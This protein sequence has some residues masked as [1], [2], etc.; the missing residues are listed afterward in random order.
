MKRKQVDFNSKKWIHDILEEQSSEE[1][2]FP[3]NDSEILNKEKKWFNDTRL[4][5]LFANKIDEKAAWLQTQN[6][7]RAPR[8][9]TLK[10]FLKYAAILAIPLLI[11]SVFFFKYNPSK[12]NI[13]LAQNTYQPKKVTLIL[14][15]GSNVDLGQ[16]KN[17]TGLSGLVNQD[18][19][20]DYTSTE[21][22]ANSPV[23]NTLVVPKG[24]DYKLV[25]EDSTQV[26]VNA[27]TRIRYQVNLSKTDTREIYLESGEAYFKVT[28]NPKKPFIVHHGNMNVQVLGTSFNVN[29]YSNTIQTTLEEGKVKV[30]AGSDNNL[31][32]SPGQQANFNKNNG[33][34]QKQEVDVYSFVSWKE[35][36]IVFNNETTA[37]FMERVGRLYDY[38]IQIKD[39]EIKQWHY[40]GIVKKSSSVT[41][42]LNMI[43]DISKLKFTIKER[44]IVVEKSTGN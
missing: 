10:P 14:Q 28:K 23:F 36:V 11:G 1:H 27:D 32:L 44:S 18:S 16:T 6:K 29:A 33:L 5:A 37:E 24:F 17:V 39:E 35:G 38:D 22:I 41:D 30:S 15:D 3:T 12:T 25:L 13:A 34:L 21:N 31:I 4:K 42:V 9:I 2:L 43:Q 8:I 26:W 20:L 40:S 19:T 7:H